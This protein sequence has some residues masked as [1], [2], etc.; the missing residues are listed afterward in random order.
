MITGI[1][2]CCARAASSHAAGLV[3]GSMHRLLSAKGC[4]FRVSNWATVPLVLA[5]ENST[6]Q[7]CNSFKTFFLQMRSNAFFEQKPAKGSRLVRREALGRIMRKFF[8][9][10]AA[11]S[12]LLATLMTANAADEPPYA[13]PVAPPVYLPQPF[14]WTGFYIGLNLGGAWSQRNLTD[15]LLGL[16]LS[17]L[18]DRGAF[19][20]GGQLGFNYQFGNFVLGIE[21]D[22]DG[23]ATTNS[24]GTGVV[25]PAFGTIQVTSDNRWITTLA[26]RFGVT[27]DTWLFYGK[28]GGGWVGSDNLTITNTVTS[29][30]IT[31]FT[32]NTTSGW[33]VGGGIEWALA[34]NWSVKVEYDYLGLNSRTFTVPAGTFL[35]G[36]TFSTSNPNVQMVKVGA[37]YLFKYGAG[38]Y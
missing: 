16:S 19:I 37:N 11:L 8:Y 28:A 6:L 3:V 18:N 25:G 38:G 26:G 24:P 30:S 2:P 4:K 29:A 27:N 31:G 15:T 32:N 21:A 1:A 12:V 17:N 33:L 14:S 20:G 22:F 7:S 13:R 9:A 10:T 23:V 36:D 35:A 5:P 34:P